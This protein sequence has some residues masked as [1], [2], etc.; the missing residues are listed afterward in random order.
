[1]FV[2]GADA[3]PRAHDGSA[4]VPVT[5]GV[6]KKQHWNE[7]N[8]QHEGQNHGLSQQ[9]VWGPFWTTKPLKR[10]PQDT[11]FFVWNF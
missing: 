1:M 3:G 5:I 11:Q 2:H 7:A 9:G 6:G 4:Q 8:K 10:T